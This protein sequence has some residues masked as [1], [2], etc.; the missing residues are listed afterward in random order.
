MDQEARCYSSRASRA[1]RTKG[2]RPIPAR[3]G[4]GPHGGTADGTCGSG[5]S[6]GRVGQEVESKA[7]TGLVDE[8]WA[9]H[10]NVERKRTRCSRARGRRSQSTQRQRGQGGV[11]ASR[12]W[13]RD[14]GCGGELADAMRRL[15]YRGWRRGRGEDVHG[16][17]SESTDD[18]DA[19]TQSRAST[20]TRGCAGSSARAA[21]GASAAS[22]VEGCGGGVARGMLAVRTCEQAVLQVDRLAVG[23]R[24]R[25][26]AASKSGDFAIIRENT[27]GEYW[28][29]QISD[30]STEPTEKRSTQSAAA[31]RARHHCA[32]VQLPRVRVLP[33][34]LGAG[35]IE[36]RVDTAGSAM[37]RDAEGAEYFVSKPGC[38]VATPGVGMREKCERVERGIAEGRADAAGRAMVMRA[39]A[40]TW[41]A[42]DTSEDMVR[43][44]G[45][46]GAQHGALCHPEDPSAVAHNWSAPLAQRCK[47]AATSCA[48]AVRFPF[49]SNSV[50]PR[51]TRARGADPARS[52]RASQ[53][54]NWKQFGA[55]MQSSQIRRAWC[56]EPSRRANVRCPGKPNT[57]RRK[58]KASSGSSVRLPINLPLIAGL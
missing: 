6:G 21:R 48:A 33:A 22:C 13:L 18:I 40:L 31:W 25:E 41:S 7:A 29:S 3:L 50:R 38:G 34:R 15:W 19:T 10:S 45:D 2:R 36:R 51:P 43:R 11:C 16:C 57:T 56:L 46:L 28:T 54:M 49:V 44:V 4:Y 53:L 47:R 42:G 58:Q 24:G 5:P 12:A 20:A 35:D 55:S 37:N 8:T 52:S 26:I 14:G 23:L 1:P 39:T 32:H 17:G 27:E 9:Y 30:L